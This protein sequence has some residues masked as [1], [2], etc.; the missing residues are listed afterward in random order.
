[1]FVKH[2]ATACTLNPPGGQNMKRTHLKINRVLLYYQWIV[3]VKFRDPGSK[4]SQ[5]RARKPKWDGQTD[6]RTDMPNAICLP[7]N[8]LRWH[9]KKSHQT[10]STFVFKP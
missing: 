1:M 7:Q 4:R 6:G 9:N 3:T 2:Y 5:V 8:Y 10:Y